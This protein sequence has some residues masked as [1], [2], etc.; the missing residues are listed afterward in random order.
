MTT[1]RHTCER[2]GAEFDC[3]AGGEDGGCWC[4]ALPFRMPMPE[5]GAKIPYADC[6]CRTC[7]EAVAEARASG[8]TPERL[9]T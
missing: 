7:L 1:R 3:G 8:P 9:P 6:L 2:C 4:A 5:P